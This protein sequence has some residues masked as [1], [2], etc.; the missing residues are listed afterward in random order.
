MND[1]SFRF[2]TSVVLLPLAFVLA[3]WLGFW[4]DV[5]FNLDMMDYGIYPRTLEGLRGVLLSPFIHG[6]LEHL[7][8]NTIPMFLLLMA[9][10][11]FYREQS[12]PVVFYGILVS[13]LLTWI[14]GR[15][16]HH[17][18]ASSL[19]YVLAS[20]IFFKGIRAGN[21]KLVAVSLTVTLIYGS[22]LWYVFP[23]IEQQISWEGHLSGFLTGLAF[24]MLFKTQD[25][26]KPITYDWERPDFDP[27]HDKFLQRF[28]EN[29]N[30]VNLPPPEPEPEDLPALPPH[31][32]T[33]QPGIHVVYRFTPKENQENSST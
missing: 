10:R 22:M 11:Y 6:G 30:F 5:R 16:S 31:Q 13:G 9:L 3:M 23:G 29:G 24:A 17:I 14:I 12:L 33:T 28:D 21:L 25:Y 2:S 15:E 19:I 18:G 1:Q 26:Q 20:F 4:A 27:S 32:I 8:N 7:Y